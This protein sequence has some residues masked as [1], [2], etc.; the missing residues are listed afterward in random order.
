MLPHD[1]PGWI[2]SKEAKSLFSQKEDR[3]AFGEMD[4]S[5]KAKS[6]KLR[7]GCGRRM[8]I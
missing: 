1:E 3:Y 2:T 8:S 5:R 7:F 6:R 4:D